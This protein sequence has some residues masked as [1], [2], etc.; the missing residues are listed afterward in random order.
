MI[1][2]KEKLSLFEDWRIE[3]IDLL[4]NSKIDKDEFLNRNY[5]FLTD[6]GLKP[7]SQIR[8]LE[9]A[10]YNY[11]YY[12]IMA[13]RSNTKALKIVNKFR[14]KK[15]Y[16]QYINNRENFYY[17]KDLASKR[18]LELVNYENTEAYFI[19]LRSKRLTGKIFE[20]VISNY[21]KIILH[22][23]NEEILKSLIDKKC[24]SKESRKS[25]IDS[26]V[27]KSY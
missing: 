6:L 7:F 8:D 5:K 19:S 9:E 25:K 26:Y 1:I 22:S 27:N 3:S 10:I 20:I 24:F 4:S 14:K 17:L 11:Q 18:L 21:D 15:Q 2:E 23:K 16:K 12:N 13:K